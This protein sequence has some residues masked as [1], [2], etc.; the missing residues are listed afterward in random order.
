M[1]PLFIVSRPTYAEVVAA[2]RDCFASLSVY[3][4]VFA[5]EWPIPRCLQN[6]LRLWIGENDGRLI[7]DVRINF[8]LELLGDR[9]HSDRHCP[10]H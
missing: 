3:F 2:D 6:G 7:I 1:L 4:H 5:V 9:R 10:L 8:R